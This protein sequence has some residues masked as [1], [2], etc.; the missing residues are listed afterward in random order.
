MTT[1]DQREG[2]APRDPRAGGSQTQPDTTHT[3]ERLQRVVDTQAQML[4]R[5][6]AR[7]AELEDVIRKGTRLVLALRE[8]A[9]RLWAYHDWVGEHDCPTTSREDG[10]E[11]ARITITRRLTPDG[12]DQTGFYLAPDDLAL[13][14]TLGLLRLAE[15]TAI[16][17]AQR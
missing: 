10:F 5:R 2:S 14:E 17:E 13:V 7:L 3:T 11:T 12:D 9:D 6:D 1:D 8:Q 15:D 4:E 16:A